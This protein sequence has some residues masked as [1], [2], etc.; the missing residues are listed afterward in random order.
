[1]VG[2]GFDTDT[3]SAIRA[4][5]ANYLDKVCRQM[6]REWPDRVR[7]A[8]VD[9]ESVSALLDAIDRHGPELVV[10]TTHGQGANERR[11][12]GSV[13]EQVLCRAAVPLLL[14]RPS[15]PASDGAAG[16]ALRCGIVALDLSL[17]AEMILGPVRDFAFATQ[18]HVTLV[19]A[20]D[21]AAPVSGAGLARLSAEAQRYLDRLADRLRA[22]GMRV[23]TRVLSG[24]TPAEGILSLLDGRA[25]WVA[26]TPHG[27]GGATNLMLGSVADK[28]VR[29]TLKPVLFYRP[30]VGPRETR[31][32]ESAESHR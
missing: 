31:G 28:V 22:E 23:A 6:S 14:V 32:S 24:S 13:A 10:L 16:L 30:G 5:Q 21:P 25:D 8:L 20:L 12:L 19:H 9:G 4:G 27:A 26:L 1:M 11:W 17:Q 18:S 2:A 3:D 15:A 7:T 29:G